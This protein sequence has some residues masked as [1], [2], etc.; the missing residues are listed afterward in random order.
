M[1]V[2]SSREQAKQGM[3]MVFDNI[4]YVQGHVDFAK[5]FGDILVTVETDT[6]RQGGEEVQSRRMSIYEC[7]DG[8]LHRCWSLP[9][10]EETA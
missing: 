3:K 2:A 10:K 7:Q 5:Q 6:I 9:V 8:K 4:D 1:Q